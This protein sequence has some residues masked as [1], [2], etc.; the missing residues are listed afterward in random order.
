[1]TIWVSVPWRGSFHCFSQSQCVRWFSVAST[2]ALIWVPALRR[3]SWPGDRPFERGCRRRSCLKGAQTKLFPSLASWPASLGTEIETA[4]LY[5]YIRGA[6]K[7]GFFWPKFWR[8]AEALSLEFFCKALSFLTE[9]LSFSLAFYFSFLKTL[10][11]T[12]IALVHLLHYTV[13]TQN[14]ILTL[15][16][17]KNMAIKMTLN[18]KGINPTKYLKMNIF[19]IFFGWNLQNQRKV[20]FLA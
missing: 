15:Q 12:L 20:K 9:F 7:A 4:F 6:T 10:I 2:A 5:K 19:W 13:C 18:F 16:K 3:T 14:H 8:Q 11:F 17:S 1:M